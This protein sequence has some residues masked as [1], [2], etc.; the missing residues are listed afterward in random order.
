MHEIPLLSS[1]VFDFFKF[2]LILTMKDNLGTSLGFFLP[3]ASYL[4]TP[5]PSQRSL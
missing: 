5:S 2:N 1:I 3:Y 4:V